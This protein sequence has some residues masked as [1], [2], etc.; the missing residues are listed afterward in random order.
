MKA[1]KQ[2]REQTQSGPIRA[3]AHSL[4]DMCSSAFSTHTSMLLLY[5]QAQVIA[6]LQ[7]IYTCKSSS[8]L[9]HY[10][11]PGHG[12]CVPLQYFLII[13]GFFYGSTRTHA[14]RRVE[15]DGKRKISESS[16]EEMRWHDRFDKL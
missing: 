11:A 3:A 15:E 12:D 4:P 13:S 10:E 5:G 8:C 14:Q 9:V 7:R 16:E 2:A 1:Y 6:A